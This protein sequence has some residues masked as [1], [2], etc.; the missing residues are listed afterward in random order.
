MGKNRKKIYGPHERGYL[1]EHS[2]KVTSY[3][4]RDHVELPNNLTDPIIS[5]NIATW[6]FDYTSD[7]LGNNEDQS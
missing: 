7:E 1:E 2:K 3:A 6:E 5:N 4:L